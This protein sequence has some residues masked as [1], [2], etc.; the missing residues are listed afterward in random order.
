M[1]NAIP[2]AVQ[3]VRPHLQPLDRKGASVDKVEGEMKERQHGKDG[4]IDEDGEDAEVRTP[5][6]A[7]KPRTPTR[8]EIDAHYPLHA[9]YRDW[10]PHCVAGK[11]IS[12]QH[13]S[14]KKPEEEIGTT[15]SMDYL[16]MVPEE[17]E[18]DMDAV[19]IVYDANRRNM[20]TM[21]TDSKGPTATSVKWVIDRLNDA[22]YAGVELTLKTDQEPAILEL[23]RQIGIKREAVTTMIESPVRESKSNGM[24]ERAVKAWQVALKCQ[25]Q[26]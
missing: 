17:A 23:K 25:N 15:V 21:V 9:D 24:V 4:V 1:T 14:G 18:E 16:F 22:G 26:L 10:C 8:A 3:T 7:R 20:W 13:R 11:G 19:L 2:Q 5:K 12:N 6:V